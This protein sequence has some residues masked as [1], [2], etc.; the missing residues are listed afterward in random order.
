[1][2]DLSERY[3]GVLLHPTCLPSPYGIGDFGKGA[4]DFIN[5]LAGSGQKLWQ[6][7]PLGP[8]GYGDSPY[9]SFSSFARQPLLISPDI[10]LQQGLLDGDHRDDSRH[11]P[12]HLCPGHFEGRH[13]RGAREV[14]RVAG[15]GIHLLLYRELEAGCDQ[16]GLRVEI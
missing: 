13:C 8:T 2:S 7:L 3:S 11:L 9:Q 4:Y 6:I 15:G 14:S 5:F 16:V 12:H 1:M 10:L